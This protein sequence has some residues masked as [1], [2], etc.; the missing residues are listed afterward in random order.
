MTGGSGPSSG[1]VRDPGFVVRV[2]V[3]GASGEVVVRAG[4]RVDL[5]LR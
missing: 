5:G 2:A 4:D 3:G 1:S